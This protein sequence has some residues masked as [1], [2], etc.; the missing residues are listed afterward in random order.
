MTAARND[1]AYKKRTNLRQLRVYLR[2]TQ[3]DFIDSCYTDEHSSRRIS[4]ATLSNLESK[5]GTA[6]NAVIASASRAYS[7][8]ESDFE[9]APKDFV[10]L[11]DR[12]FADAEELD[13]PVA[14]DKQSPIAEL[15]NRLTQYFAD[16]IFE[17]SLSRGDKIE[18]D[19]ELAE[20]F[21][22]GRSALREAMKVLDVMGLVDIRQ[23][24][25]TFI[26]NRD[27]DFFEIPLLWS[28][29]LS[30]DQIEQILT[31]RTLLECE[32]AL[33]A[34]TAAS[35]RMKDK[36]GK[37]V[38][39]SYE[40]VS[41]NDEAKLLDLD[42]E[43]HISIAEYSGNHLISSQIKTIRNLLRRVSRTGMSSKSE[44]RNICKEHE[45]IYELICGGRGA[46]AMGAMTRHLENSKGRYKL[47]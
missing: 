13:V 7:I 31:L 42:V 23:G 24:Q 36:L 45:E 19:R 8:D 40:A 4:V 41:E 27:T 9:L 38:K 2:L 33:L 17:G 32:S 1:A 16:R 10:R 35:A 25:G 46:E 18:P 12:H 21:G 47:D 3:K 44:L 14:N 22:V 5:G 15:V 37:I 28:M 30:N 29:F 43:F 11:L 6:L 34:S 20:K 39:E 26:S